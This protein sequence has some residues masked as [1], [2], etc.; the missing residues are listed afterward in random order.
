MNL[1]PAFD[2]LL[3][4]ACRKH[5][6]VLG[7]KLG[8]T[9]KFFLV[10][11]EPTDRD[12]MLERPF[13]GAL[14]DVLVAAMQTVG[15]KYGASPEDFYATYLVKCKFK[16]GNLTEKQVL[17]EWL[18]LLQVEYALSGCSMVVCVG[19][20]SRLFAGHVQHLPTFLTVK[21]ATTQ[22]APGWRE[23]IKRWLSH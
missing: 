9:P 13:Q 19:K 14:G 1:Q 16:E 15:D 22:S 3:D 6:P 17:D 11:D 5:Q 4:A 10:G 12:L 18:P 8:D 21:Q 23:R 7:M 2:K 20:V